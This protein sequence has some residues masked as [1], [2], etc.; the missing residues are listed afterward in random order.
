MNPLRSIAVCSVVV[1]LAACPVKAPVYDYAKEP[2]PRK[3]EY[4][5]GVGDALSINVWENGGLS[6]DATIRP[7]GTITMPLVGDLRAA[8]ETPSSLRDQI[9]KRVAD[10]VKLQ[11]SEITVAVREANSYRFTLAGEV[12]RAG[13]YNPAY[14][15]P[16]V[17]AIALAGGFSRFAK[18]NEITLMR[19]DPKTGKIR[20]IPLAYD[21]LA[22]GERPDMN[23][24]LVAGDAL[25]VP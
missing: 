4:V 5:L 17:E 22:S 9:K 7:D 3:S 14:Y 16:V 23:L 20:A 25:F 8:G 24:V 15:V 11:G 2:D 10:F 21:L 13:V 12:S 1:L 6:T 18:R 19:R